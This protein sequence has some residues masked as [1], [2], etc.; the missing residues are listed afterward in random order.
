MDQKNLNKNTRLG[1]K[2]FDFL[3]LPNASLDSFNEVERIINYL[4]IN[5]KC[6][7]RLHPIN[8][9]NINYFKKYKKIL[10]KNKLDKDIENSKY[11]IFVA[12]VF[13]SELLQLKN[14]STIF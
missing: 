2:K 8:N 10:S 5:Y 6:L 9:K 13:I 1:K 14:N 11:I 12:I 4:K 7:V 3:I